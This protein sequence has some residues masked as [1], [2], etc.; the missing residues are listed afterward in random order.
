MA[1]LHSLIDGVGLD[2]CQS[3][4]HCRNGLGLGLLWSLYQAQLFYPRSSQLGLLTCEDLEKSNLLFF[5][6]RLETYKGSCISM[7]VFESDV[8]DVAEGVGELVCFQVFELDMTLQCPVR[9]EAHIHLLLLGGGW[10]GCRCC[11]FPRIRC[12]GHFDGV[13]GKTWW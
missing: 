13:E 12:V 2:T 9:R 6:G 4:R 10:G 5:K 8:L 3:W 7:D 1:A 11:T